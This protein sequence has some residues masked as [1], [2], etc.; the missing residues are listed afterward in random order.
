MR[1]QKLLG[2]V[3]V[4]CLGA[5]AAQAADCGPLGLVTTLQMEMEDGM[6]MI[7]VTI[8]G[9]PRRFLLDTGGALPQISR[10]IVD[11][12]KLRRRDSSIKLLDVNGNVTDELA[13]IDTFALGSLTKEDVPM[14]IDA[15]SESRDGVLTQA[16]YS[17]FD[18][19][20]DFGPRRFTLFSQKHCPGGVVYWKADAVAAVPIGKI[21]K[22]NL[23]IKLTVTIDGHDRHRGK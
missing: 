15:G 16:L 5:G 12:L 9:T 8:N 11:E 1:I 7:P 4:A 6:P 19:D 23:H 2:L 21:T 14:L 13:V 3:A 22:E 18:M 20:L 17:N 10:T